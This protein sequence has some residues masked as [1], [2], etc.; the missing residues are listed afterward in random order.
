[1]PYARV[2]DASG[3]DHIA[4]N[5]RVRMMLHSP[6]GSPTGFVMDDGTQVFSVP[7][8]ADAVAQQVTPGQIVRVEGR[9]TRTTAGTGMWAISI[10]QPS[11]LVLL[12]MNRGVGAPE[13]NLR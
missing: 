10:T 5:G 8:V 7:T 2:D 6:A 4:S 13:L 1:V 3:L 11:G 12:D 9:G